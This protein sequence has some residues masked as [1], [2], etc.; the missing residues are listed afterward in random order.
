MPEHK[1][2]VKLKFTI[3]RIIFLVVLCALIIIVVYF[4]TITKPVFSI[5]YNGQILKF[6]VDLREADKLTVF[7]ESSIYEL[8]WNNSVKNV[9][10]VFMDTTDLNHVTVEA[11]EV[12][13]KLKLAYNIFNFST[14]ISAQE[15]ESFENLSKENVF[16]A[17]VPPSISNETI[18]KINDNVIFIKA[19][20]YEEFD[21]AT[22]KFIM[23]VLN[24]KLRF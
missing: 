20:T 10:I 18:V 24:I 2:K 21:L 13:Y 1:K 7:D 16:I 23:V 11:I 14:N 12:A 15:V 9:T 19:K 5:N 17:L 6:R 8:L 22:A 4:Y 3:N